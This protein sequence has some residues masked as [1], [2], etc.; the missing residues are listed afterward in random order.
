[1]VICPNCV[2]EQPDWA[3]N[4]LECGASLSFLRRHPQRVG[5]AIWFSMLAGLALLVALLARVLDR[6]FAAGIPG[7]GWLDAGQ[8]ALGI[9]LSLL[10]SRG[11]VTLK[12]AVVQ[13]L[14]SRCSR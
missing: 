7:F 10:G 4:C 13:H 6:F 12:D 5:F 1:M 2:T 9:L 8:L 3:D 11:W 14:P